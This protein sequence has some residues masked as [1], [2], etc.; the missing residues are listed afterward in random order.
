MQNFNFGHLVSTIVQENHIDQIPGNPVMP[1]AQL[2]EHYP[3]D[4]SLHFGQAVSDFVH[5]LHNPGTNFDLL[6]F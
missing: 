6:A 2:I 4:P 3:G 5:D 1:V